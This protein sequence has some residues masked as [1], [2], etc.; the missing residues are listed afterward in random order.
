MKKAYKVRRFQNGRNASGVPFYNYSLTI[1]TE[2]AEQMPDD[3][4]FQVELIDGIRLPNNGTIPEHFR[5]KTL[6]GLLFVPVM[7][8][9][10]V[11]LPE[12]AREANELADMMDNGA[13][14]AQPRRRPRKRPGT[15]RKRP[16]TKA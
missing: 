16:G 3:L 5:G 6:R 15:T 8:D 12:W 13:D 2:I 10:V 14:G 7:A 4:R 9:E 11:E 1:P